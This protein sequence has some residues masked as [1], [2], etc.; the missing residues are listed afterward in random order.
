MG[1]ATSETRDFY[2]SMILLYRGNFIGNQVKAGAL[3]GVGVRVWTL[4]PP[5]PPSCL[6]PQDSLKRIVKSQPGCSQRSQESC[7]SNRLSEQ[8]RRACIPSRGEFPVGTP[9]PR[10]VQAPQV[11]ISLG[12]ALAAVHR[13]VCLMIAEKGSNLPILGGSP[14]AARAATC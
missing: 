5:C 12:E 13:A 8:N 11:G 1:W 14:R 9:R 3:A 2:N 10:A 4:P 7:K 6:E